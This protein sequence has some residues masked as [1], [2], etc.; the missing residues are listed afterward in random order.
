MHMVFIKAN[1]G[2]KCYV[3]NCK[4]GILWGLKDVEPLTSC[5]VCTH[6][7]AHTHTGCL[8]DCL[9]SPNESILFGILLK[10]NLYSVAYNR[11]KVQ[12]CSRQYRVLLLQQK[13]QLRLC[14]S[15]HSPLYLYLSALNYNAAIISWRN[16]LKIGFRVGF[17]GVYA[18][19]YE[20]SIYFVACCLVRTAEELCALPACIVAHFVCIFMKNI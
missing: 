10:N 9:S 18:R 8:F 16:Q 7:H 17:S 11:S 5:G 13:Q 2:A 3:N 15:A 14:I 20:L 19:R 6:T 12:R 4:K 1:V